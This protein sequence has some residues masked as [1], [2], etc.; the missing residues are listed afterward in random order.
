MKYEE[1]KAKMEVMAL[2]QQEQ[3]EQASKNSAKSTS[4]V[5]EL[6][7]PVAERWSGSIRIAAWRY[8]FVPTVHLHAVAQLTKLHFHASPSPSTSSTS[9]SVGWQ[10]A[11]WYWVSLAFGRCA[12]SGLL[13]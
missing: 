4:I 6:L 8:T 1:M 3:A 2:M 5:A 12:L 7:L 11:H 13:S 10:W 9:A